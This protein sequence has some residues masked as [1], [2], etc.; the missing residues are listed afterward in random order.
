MDILVK[1]NSKAFITKENSQNSTP[2]FWDF[3]KI[4]QANYSSQ[5]N[6]ICFY[7]EGKRN[8]KSRSMQ[9]LCLNCITASGTRA[10]IFIALPFSVSFQ[11]WNRSS[12]I[13]HDQNTCNN[14]VQWSQISMPH[15]RSCKVIFCHMRAM[16]H[17]ARPALLS[18]LV[19]TMP[20]QFLAWYHRS[21]GQHQAS[22][23]KLYFYGS[24]GW[25]MKLNYQGQS[26][27]PFC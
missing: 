7:S 3:R 25:A 8:L 27:V 21:R 2:L 26:C 12:T 5:R 13:T 18:T 17:V 15:N 24:F 20:T 1:S 10:D 9:L 4:I 16:S 22:M 19:S 11:H 6:I 23:D 14:H